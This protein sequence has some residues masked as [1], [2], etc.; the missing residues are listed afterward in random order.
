MEDK[1]TDVNW[2]RNFPSTS[3][4]TQA[5]MDFM[6][7][8]ALPHTR[9]TV[10]TRASVVSKTGFLGKHQRDHCQIVRECTYPPYVQTIF[11]PFFFSLSLTWDHMRRKIS[12]GISYE[13]TQQIQ[14]Q[15]SMRTLRKDHYQSC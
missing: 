14:S 5:M 8:F 15:H 2:S 11:S 9:A 3:I 13:S 1:R 6:L 10:F 7:C 12:N 4:C